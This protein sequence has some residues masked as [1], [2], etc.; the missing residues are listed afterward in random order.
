MTV[1]R[2][3]FNLNFIISKSKITFAYFDSEVYLQFD[4]KNLINGLV[5]STIIIYNIRKEFL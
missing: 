4:R 5:L 3:G 1:T 2:L